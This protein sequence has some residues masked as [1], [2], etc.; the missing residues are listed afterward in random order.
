MA[1]ATPSPLPVGSR[2]L[3]ALGFLACTLPGV[4]ILMPMKKPRG[5]E[6]PLEEQRANQ[7]LHQ[8]RQAVSHGARPDAPVEGGRPRS[9]DGALLCPA[10]CPSAPEPLAAHDLIGINSI[11]QSIVAAHGG[12]IWA[13]PQAEQGTTLCLTLPLGDETGPGE[14]RDAETA[15]PCQAPLPATRRNA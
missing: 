3:Q 13:L 5:Q 6:L 7:A 10:Q 12:Q 15:P 4:V 14:E 1:D 2:L 8:Q 9:R 11:S